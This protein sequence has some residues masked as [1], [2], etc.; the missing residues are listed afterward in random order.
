MYTCATE[1]PTMKKKS[2]NPRRKNT[3]SFQKII[4]RCNV[5]QRPVYEHEVCP[6]FTSKTGS[7]LQKNCKTCKHSF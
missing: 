6:Q 1:F 2:N 3:E 7:D 4:I 5:L